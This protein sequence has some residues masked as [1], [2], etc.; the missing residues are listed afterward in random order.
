[1]KI[2]GLLFILMSLTMAVNAAKAQEGQAIYEILFKNVNV[3][4]G[5]NEKLIN[6]INV[7]VAG[8]LIKDF[9]KELD[10]NKYATIIDGGGRTLMPGLSDAHVH[11]MLNDTPAGSVS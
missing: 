1:M 11:L 4:D 3:F 7:L 10:V 8:N 5:K 6:N 2:K 9:G